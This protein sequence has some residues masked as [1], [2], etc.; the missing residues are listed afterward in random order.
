ML[1]S[2]FKML[3]FSCCFFTFALPFKD[4]IDFG[5]WLRS[6][7]FRGPHFAKNEL[8]ALEFHRRLQES[9]DQLLDSS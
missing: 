2:S 4:P 6:R 3:Q 8:L 5:M 7:D 9:G 1:F